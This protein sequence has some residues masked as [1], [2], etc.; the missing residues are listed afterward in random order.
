MLISCSAGAYQHARKAAS[1][2]RSSPSCEV[3][4]CLAGH[5]DDRANLVAA[6]ED[7]LAGQRGMQGGDGRETTRWSQ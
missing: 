3:A 2:L 1:R 5:L 7:Q 6:G 4:E